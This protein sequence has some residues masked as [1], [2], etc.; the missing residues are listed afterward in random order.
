M[1]KLIVAGTTHELAED[2]ST[3]GR[4][5]ENSVVIN[6]V[7]VSGRH[8]QI[9]RSGQIYKLRDLG[10]TNGTRVNGESAH[11]VTLRQGDRLRFGGVEA[12]FESVDVKSTQP[13]PTA[14]KIELPTAEVSSRPADFANASP[15]KLR[16]SQRDRTR[17]LLFVAAALAALLMLAALLVT[18]TMRAPTP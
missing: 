10:S 1:A 14:Q 9:E 5:P 16:S 6:D 13:L 12:R 18:I 8:A 3:I 2:L 11:E 15:F 7:S 17:T 4:A